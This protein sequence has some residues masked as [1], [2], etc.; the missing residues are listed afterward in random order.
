MDTGTEEEGRR[1]RVRR[2]LIDPLSEDGMRF[3]RDVK[4]ENAQA[5]L[6]RIADDF[7]YM[8]DTA[9]AV[10]RRALSV[11]GEGSA[12]CFWPAYITIRGVAHALEPAPFEDDPA[13]VRWFRSRAGRD[14]QS[15]GRAV[16]EYEFFRRK[17]RPPFFGERGTPERRLI[18]ERAADYARK[19]EL[20]KDRIARGVDLLPGE[21]EWLE[22]YE[23]TSA[24]VSQLIS[25]GAEAVDAE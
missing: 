5:H 17:C 18:A 25:E 12:K 24:H 9:L 6:D 1:A 4:P 14:A 23:R 11:M 21:A 7:A 19:E 8:S 3:K 22:W 13:L 16:A 2:L 10:L 15:A 20:A